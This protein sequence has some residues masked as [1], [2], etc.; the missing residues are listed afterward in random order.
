MRFL[1]RVE[2]GLN[3]MTDMAFM[4]LN[5][6]SEMLQMIKFVTYHM[7]SWIFISKSVKVEINILFSTCLTLVK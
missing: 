6:Y 5:C 2:T 4:A 3:E 1:K 7:L